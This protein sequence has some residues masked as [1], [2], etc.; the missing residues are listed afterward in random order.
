MLEAVLFDLDDTLLGN[1]MDTFIPRYFALLGQYAEAYLPRDE[2]LKVLMSA[3]RAMMA[4]T[5]LSLTNREVFW[6]SFHEQTGLDSEEMELFFDKF[7]RNQFLALESVV[8]RRETAV[9]LVNFFQQKGYKV[10]IAT[11]PMFPQPAVE[12]RLYWAGLPVTEFDFDLVTTY[13]NMHVTKPHTLYFE[14]ILARIGVAADKV[15]MV[16]DDWKND[17]APAASI[18]CF[19]FWLPMNGEAAPPDASLVTE[20]GTLRELYNLVNACWLTELGD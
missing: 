12:A 7:Y 14:E 3:T 5:D 6:Q 2:F 4:D 16:G 20:Y 9:S 11:N 15:L 1:H 17:I 10:V 19:T 13:E 8:T 18:G